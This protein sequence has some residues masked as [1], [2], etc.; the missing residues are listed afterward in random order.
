MHFFEYLGKVITPII[1][2]SVIIYAIIEH[3]NVFELFIQGVIEGEKIVIKL[4]PTLLALLVAVGM[5]SA[6]GITEFI[7]KGIIK[8][9]PAMEEY[10]SLVPFILLRPI[11]G[12]TSNAIGTN[13]MQNIGVDTKIGIL[14]SLIIGSTETT[15]Y[16]ISVYGS[17]LEGKNMKPALILGL[18]ADFICIVSCFVFI[19]YLYF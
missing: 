18:L 6:S 16:V 14:T 3:K 7:A 9:F 15:I 17:K 13:I 1:L 12:S 4:F 11:S 8:I 19:N 5:L 2:V 10:K